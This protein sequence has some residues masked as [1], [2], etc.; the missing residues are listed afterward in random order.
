MD[1]TQPFT[2]VKCK[3][4]T[5]GRRVNW[6][7]YDQTPTKSGT[8]PDFLCFLFLEFLENLC[9]RGAAAEQDC[10]SWRDQFFRTFPRAWLRCH[11]THGSPP[12]TLSALDFMFSLCCSHKCN[13]KEERQSITA[14]IASADIYLGK[15]SDG[16]PIKY[17]HWQFAVAAR[18]N[19]P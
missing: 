8:E 18:A 6:L 15:F 17:E 16:F 4:L 19:D 12:L 11:C 2:I 1:K 14:L 13:D 9:S 7:R 5:S 3:W 10:P